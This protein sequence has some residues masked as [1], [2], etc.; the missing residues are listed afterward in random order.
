MESPPNFSRKASPSTK[1]TI[2]SP[3][4]AAAGTAQTSLRSIAAG[5]SLKVFRSTDRSGCHQRGDRLHE[6]GNTHVLAVGD[7]TFE[8]A[9]V[10]GRTPQAGGALRRWQNLVVDLGS[11]T[12]RHF[13]TD[14]DSDRLDGMDAHQ[15]LCETPIE[16]AIPLHVGAES[17][18]HAGG[19]DLEGAAESVARLFGRVD[20]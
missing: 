14:A 11:W 20:R 17:R 9:G 2:A 8:P 7:A 16:L 5:A 1:A 10:V 13:R 19:D 6:S 3:T 15:R 4:T 12:D 18:G